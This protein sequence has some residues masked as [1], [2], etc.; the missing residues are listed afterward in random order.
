MALKGARHGGLAMQQLKEPSGPKG[1]LLMGVLPRVRRDTLG[2]LSEVPRLYGPIARYRLGPLQSYLV[3]HPDGVKRVLQDHVANYTKDHVSYGMV[4]WIAGNGLVT[5]QGDFWLRQRRL[6]QPAFHRQRIG[7]M[8]G[9]MTQATNELLER[10]ADVAAQGKPLQVGPEMMGLTLRIVGDA[11]FGANM[12]QT[13]AVVGQS[14]DVL[15][16]QVV[17]RFRTFNVLPPILPTRA[18]RAFRASIKTLRGVVQ[19]LITER[20]KSGEDRG[21][22]LSMFMLARDEETGAQMDDTQIVDEAVTMMVAGHETTATT[23]SWVWA[24]LHQHPEVEARLHAEV[25]SVLAGRTPGLE[26]LPRLPYVR[27]VVDEALRLYPPVYVLSRKVLKDDELCGFR[28]RG[29]ASVDISPYATH[30]LPEFWEEPEQFRP[31]RFTPEQAANRPRFAYFPFLGGPR[32][33]IGNAFAL[34]EAQLIIACVSQRFRLRMVPGY[35]PTPE[36]LVTL[37]PVGG[38]PM[39][40]ERRL[41][42][43]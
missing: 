20:R 10:W 24:L 34:M 39:H 22:L 14:F 16:V 41:S 25:D 33:C 43:A 37:R 7:A 21:D 19:G 27:M 17:H 11:L 31:E 23:L 13:T 28:I 26:D 9:L 2:F 18:D 30:R 8:A 6:A 3:A 38:L 4:R 36:P 40:L 12:A 29:G 15:S 32:Q 35:T 42:G 5:S 1:H